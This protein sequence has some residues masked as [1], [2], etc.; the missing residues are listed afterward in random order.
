MISG[1]VLAL[2]KR[3]IK[4]RIYTVGSI[5]GEIIDRSGVEA[6]TAFEYREIPITGDFVSGKL[7]YNDC[8]GGGGYLT[9]ILKGNVYCNG[10]K[11]GNVVAG[12]GDL[13]GTAKPITTTH[14][15]QV[16]NIVS[17]FTN[18]YVLVHVLMIII[19]ALLGLG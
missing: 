9:H 7:A 8:I 6:R 12:I 3:G 14:T 10:N 16:I 17:Q 19:K 4:P 5:R 18:M 1:N 13:C 11:C 15:L 2:S